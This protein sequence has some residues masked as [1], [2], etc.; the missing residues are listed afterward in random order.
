MYASLDGRT[1]ND[2][3][4]AFPGIDDASIITGLS[5]FAHGDTAYGMLTTRTAKAPGGTAWV[6]DRNAVK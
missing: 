6:A 5:E 2:V 4:E 3:G 1:W